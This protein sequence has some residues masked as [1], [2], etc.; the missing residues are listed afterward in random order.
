MKQLLIG[1]TNDNKKV[2]IYEANTLF[3]LDCFTSMFDNY[4]DL[5]MISS[6]TLSN[7]PY[8]STPGLKPLPTA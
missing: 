4:K 3:E 6:S 1:I 8:K 5:E 2:I 7:S